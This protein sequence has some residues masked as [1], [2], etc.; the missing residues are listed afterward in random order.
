MEKDRDGAVLRTVTVGVIGFC[1]GVI[2]GLLGAAG[3]ILLVYTFPLLLRKHT[4]LPVPFCGATTPPMERRDRLATS[5]A[6][7]LPVTVVSFVSYWIS[8]VTPDLSSLALL[9]LPAM[10]GGVCGAWLLGRIRAD[11]LK[12]MFALVVIVSGIRMLM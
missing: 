3:G 8:G 12:R 5:L 1:A 9:I 6:V 2:N 11:F 4:P 10:L 7:M